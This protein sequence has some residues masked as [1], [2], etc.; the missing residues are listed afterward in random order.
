MR[1]HWNFPDSNLLYRRR[2]PSP[3]QRSPFIL[4]FFRP[5]KR[6]SVF[7]WKGSSSN[8]F[9]TS[10]ARPSMPYRRSVYPHAM[11]TCSNPAASLSTKQHLQCQSDL[12]LICF[13]TDFHNCTRKSNLNIA[14]F[15]NYR[16]NI[17]N[18]IGNKCKLQIF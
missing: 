1:G 7:I 12:C 18:R 6:K 3:S 13:M 14:L 4:S 17:S 5:Q 2:N 15:W 11:Y 16:T 10:V 8:L 9:F